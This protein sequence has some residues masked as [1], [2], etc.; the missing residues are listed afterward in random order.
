MEEPPILLDG[1]LV[2][3][4]ATLD[5]AV[6]LGERRSVVVEGVSMDTGT[7]RR[8][9]I[10]ENLADGAIFLVHCNDR[11]ETLSAGPCGDR[12]AARKAAAA[13]FSDLPFTWT[14]MRPLSPEEEREV[15]STRAFLRHLVAG[16][17]S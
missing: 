2:L 5:P 7:V 10:A 8:L 3:E 1:A 14:P 13:S 17:D 15:R 12:A 4:Y 9:V 11:W 6:S 16:D